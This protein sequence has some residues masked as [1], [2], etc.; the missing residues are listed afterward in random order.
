MPIVI[1]LVIEQ[2]VHYSYT[3][4]ERVFLFIKTGHIFSNLSELILELCSAVASTRAYCIFH[5]FVAVKIFNRNFVVLHSNRLQWPTAASIFGM[6]NDD[7][8]FKK[9]LPFGCSKK[10]LNFRASNATQWTRVQT[11]SSKRMHISIKILY[12]F[13][14]LVSRLKPDDCRARLHFIR[15]KWLF[16]FLSD[17]FLL[18]FHSTQWSLVIQNVYVIQFNVV[19]KQWNWN[20]RARHQMVER[21]NQ[22][23]EWKFTECALLAAHH[24]SFASSRRGKKHKR[25]VKWKRDAIDS[26]VL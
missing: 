13:L 14:L 25:N 3:H 20:T 5:F 7:W 6:W 18:H 11:Q 17:S 4:R 2:C 9:F 26:R 24:D 12:C 19:S 21:G 8:P 15:M 1:L 23:N 10:K 22:L 16:F